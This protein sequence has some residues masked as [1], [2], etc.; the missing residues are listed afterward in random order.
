MFNVIKFK[1]KTLSNLFIGGA[2][3]PFEIGGV[4]QQTALDQEGFP[5]VPG[6]SFKGALRSIVRDDM[7]DT[8][9]TVAQ[10]YTAYLEEDKKV[11]WKHINQIIPE[12]AALKRIEGRYEETV[13]KPTAEFLFGIEG[14][15]NTPKLLFSDLLLCDEFRNKTCFSIDMKNSIDTSGDRPVSNPRTYKTARS[16]LA[17]DGEIRL[18]KLDALGNKATE[19]CRNY[20]IDNLL[21][22]NS[23]IYRL[24]NSKSRG[25]GKIAVIIENE[26]RS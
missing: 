16:G 23:G 20:I 4:D 24:G 8:A 26:T 3:I 10:L 5:C 11:N 19:L 13:K 2:P 6:S 1:I 25:Y 18:Y 12:E 14:F 21:K 15:N 17:F 9:G 22:F 7:S